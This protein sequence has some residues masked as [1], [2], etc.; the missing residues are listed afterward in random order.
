[1]TLD[2]ICTCTPIYAG[3]AGAPN[4]LCIVCNGTGLI[5]HGPAVVH[6]DAEATCPAPERRLRPFDAPDAIELCAECMQPGNAQYPLIEM[7]MHV[8]CVEPRRVA[9]ERGKIPSRLAEHLAAEKAR[10]FEEHNAAQKAKADAIAVGGLEVA[11][12]SSAARVRALEAELAETERRH[13]AEIDQLRE[14]RAGTRSKRTRKR[15]R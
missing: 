9:I 3:E 6:V 5:Q 13:A 7:M 4:P 2:A 15:R 1:V 8:V 11:L 12:R 14:P 10:K